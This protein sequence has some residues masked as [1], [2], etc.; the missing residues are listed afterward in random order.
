MPFPVEAE[1]VGVLSI[2]GDDGLESPPE[3]LVEYLAW[4]DVSAEVG[5]APDPR[6]GIGEALLEA[7]ES[8]GG[9]LLVLGAYTHSRVRQLIFGGVT[10]HV[11][12]HARVPLLMIH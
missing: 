9:D 7:C 11:L 2:N 4:H 8:W 10:R 3:A 12:E 1:A 5:P 6:R